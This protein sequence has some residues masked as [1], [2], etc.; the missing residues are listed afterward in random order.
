MHLRPEL[1]NDA[2]QQF[3]PANDHFPLGRREPK[4]NLF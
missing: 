1:Y 4:Q 2:L 3:V